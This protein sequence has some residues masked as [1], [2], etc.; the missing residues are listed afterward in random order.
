MA[1]RKSE[2]WL[3]LAHRGFSLVSRDQSLLYFF[4]FMYS[5]D[6]TSLCHLLPV[7]SFSSC[8]T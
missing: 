8:K 4:L 7:E 2:G 1:L 6:M 3:G 5:K